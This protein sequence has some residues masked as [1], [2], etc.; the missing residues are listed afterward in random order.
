MVFVFVLGSSRCSRSSASCWAPRNPRRSDVAPT[1][2]RWYLCGSAPA[3]RARQADSLTHR[4]PGP[5]P[6][7][8]RFSGR[9]LPVARREP[10]QRPA[11]SR[12]GRCASRQV[13]PSGPTTASWRG[14]GRQ[15]QPIAG[16]EVDGLAARR[17][18]RTGSSRARRPAPCRSR[19]RGPRSG[20]PA[21]STRS[22]GS[23]PSARSRAISAVSSPMPSARDR[24]ADD[25]ADGER[26]DR[27]RGADADL[28]RSPR[29]AGRARS[30][31]SPPAP[32]S[33]QR[34]RG[35]GTML[36]RRSAAV[37]LPNRYGMTGI[38][39]PIANATNDPPAAPDG[40][41]SSS[42]S[43]PSSSRTSVSSAR[44]GSW[45]MRCGDRA[46]PRRR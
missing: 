18:A 16:R 23:R 12:P 13:T 46:S 26:H 27:R 7:L 8:R 38:D 20:R 25:R 24:D 33:E 37:P 4:S 17:A 11:A 41:P 22:A 34:D 1:E 43:R 30:A 32:T 2:I 36:T 15:V 42:G 35:S 19:G 29:T 6:G 3:E 21:R 44:S 14:A 40:E 45:N 28:P 9:R 5:R 39:A 10:P 31:G